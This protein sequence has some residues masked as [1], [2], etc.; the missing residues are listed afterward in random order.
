L[1]ADVLFGGYRLAKSTIEVLALYQYIR[2]RYPDH[3][4]IYRFSDIGVGS[5]GGG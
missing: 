1:H 5:D 2:R 4:R 3:L